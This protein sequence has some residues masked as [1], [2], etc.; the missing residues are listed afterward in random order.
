MFVWNYETIKISVP[1][2]TYKEERGTFEWVI[3]CKGGE[4]KAF[5]AIYRLYHVQ[6]GNLS[7]WSVGQP[8]VNFVQSYADHCCHTL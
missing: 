4:L 2:L 3:A 7:G 6:E 1:F 5:I 8:E